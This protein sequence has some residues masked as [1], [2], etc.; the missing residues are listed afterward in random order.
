MDHENHELKDQKEFLLSI[1]PNEIVTLN[2]NDSTTA[3]PS[4]GS[5]ASSSSDEFISLNYNNNFHLNE[6]EHVEL[7]W[8]NVGYVINNSSNFKFMRSKCQPDFYQVIKNVSGK[9]QSGKLVAFLGP[10]GAGKT[11]LLE[12]IA[13]IRTIGVSGQIYVT[14]APRAKIAFCAQKDYHLPELTVKESLLFASR[15]K[16]YNSKLKK[17]NYKQHLEIVNEILEQLGLES[18]AEVRIAGCSGGQ[19]KRLTIGLELVTRPNILFLD[20]P[21]SGLDSSSCLQCIRLLQKLARGI[22]GKQISVVASIHQPSAQVLSYIDNLYILSAGGQCIYS[23]PTN[24]LMIHFKRFDLSVP[25]YQTPTDFAIEVASGDF[26]NEILEKLSYHH[27][28]MFGQNIIKEIPSHGVSV[29]K[30]VRK[31]KNQSYPFLLHIWLLFLRTNLISFRQ[32][33]MTTFRMFTNLAVAGIITIVFKNKIGEANGCVSQAL[34]NFDLTRPGGDALSNIG[35]IFFS[36]LFVILSSQ[37]PTILTFPLEIDVFLKE[38]TNGWY[39][40][41][42]YYIAKSLTDLPFQVKI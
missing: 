12:C 31:T 22:S 18:C 19:L 6:E 40:P 25:M 13:G 21:T 14:G 9:C 29:K 7:V 36:L 26:G 11:T 23:G 32:P 15:L 5:M 2:I 42:A 8:R 27:I 20:E 1:K 10:S 34:V 33:Q 37:M 16:N 39:S 35:F 3:R 28:E 17:W 24:D 38:R 41:G 4:I 30:I